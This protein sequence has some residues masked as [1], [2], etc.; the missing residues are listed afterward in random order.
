MPHVGLV[1]EQGKPLQIRKIQGLP[2]PKK[3]NLNSL[4][5]CKL[6]CILSSQEKNFSHKD[7]NTYIY[8]YL[9]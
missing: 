8:P 6:Q 2:P 7:N 5:K 1:E 9:L 4:K 3:I